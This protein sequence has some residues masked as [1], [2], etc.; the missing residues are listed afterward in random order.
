MV[1]V[2]YC[3]FCNSCLKKN[4]IYNHINNKDSH[5]I[6]AKEFIK[7]VLNSHRKK[8]I[9]ELN[10]IFSNLNIEI[11]KSWGFTGLWI[12]EFNLMSC[13][14]NDNYIEDESEDE[15]EEED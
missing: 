12:Y 8:D 3:K 4:S 14:F 7:S 10:N 1:E 9:N 11:K 13:G 2:Y 5:I 15:E 6:K